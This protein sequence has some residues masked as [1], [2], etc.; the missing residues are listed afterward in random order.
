MIPEYFYRDLF[1]VE[2]SGN[3]TFEMMC[4]IYEYLE[5]AGYTGEDAMSRYVLRQMDPAGQY[6]S[7]RE[8]YEQDPKTIAEE[9]FAEGTTNNG[10][11]TMSEEYL[12]EMIAKYPWIDP[13]LFVKQSGSDLRVQ[14]KWPES[15]LASLS[16]DYFYE[17]IFYF[18]YG[19]DAIDQ[20]DMSDRVG[21]NLFNDTH[22]LANYRDEA[23]YQGGQCVHGRCPSRRRIE[24][25]RVREFQYGFWPQRTQHD[26]SLS[27]LFVFFLQRHRAGAAGHLLHRPA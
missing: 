1:K 21:E 7:L 23:T 8:M 11:Y 13:F 6:S 16:Y 27:E 14:I 10:I 18:A 9:M 12:L 17:C 2:T 24:E 26:Q 3:V 15:Q 19:D 22:A 4:Q 5:R 20:L 25:W